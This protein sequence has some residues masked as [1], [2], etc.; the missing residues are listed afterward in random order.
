MQTG[1]DILPLLLDFFRKLQ[2]K[3]A[4]SSGNGERCVRRSRLPFS[5]HQPNANPYN[6]ATGCREKSS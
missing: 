1:M 4:V 2:K 5:N 6:Q 3:R